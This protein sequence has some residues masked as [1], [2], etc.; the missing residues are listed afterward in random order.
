[1]EL[2]GINCVDSDQAILRLLIPG[3]ELCNYSVIAYA[4]RTHESIGLDQSKTAL[5]QSFLLANATDGSAYS[6]RTLGMTS[7]RPAPEGYGP[8]LFSKGSWEDRVISA[9]EARDFYDGTGWYEEHIYRIAS[10]PD[11]E[12]LVRQEQEL[13]ARRQQY[14]KEHREQE[15]KQQQESAAA[16]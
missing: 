12:P 15:R 8:E 9:T 11:F 6:F 5:S 10:R 7:T 3:R 14:M 1:M 4:E 13:E 16:D 2:N